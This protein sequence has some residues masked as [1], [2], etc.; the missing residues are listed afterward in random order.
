V[1]V[2]IGSRI[3]QKQEGSRVKRV[4]GQSENEKRGKNNTRMDDS[5]LRRGGGGLRQ[6]GRG[7]TGGA[8]VQ[9]GRVGARGGDLDE[10]KGELR[11]ATW[12][13]Y[14][15][16]AATREEVAKGGGTE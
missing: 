16:G 4:W 2:A 14:K 1:Q 13:G 9:E 11:A 6:E 8:K 7:E 10:G 15:E 5:R 12:G 3:I